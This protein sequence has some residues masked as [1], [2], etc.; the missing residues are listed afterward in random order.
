MRIS[1]VQLG[2]KSLN[3]NV[4]NVSWVRR[5]GHGKLY[6]KHYI[7]EYKSELQIMFEEG[8]RDSSIKN[9]FWEDARTSVAKVSKSFLYPG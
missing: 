3:D 8:N 9:E 7:D 4:F 5:K 2:D 1:H 6:G